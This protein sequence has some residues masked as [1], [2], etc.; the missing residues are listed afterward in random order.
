MALKCPVGHLRIHE[1]NCHLANRTTGQNAR[2]NV[3]EIS[4]TCLGARAPSSKGIPAEETEATQTQCDPALR[5]CMTMERRD[6]L[7]LPRRPFSDPHRPLI[8]WKPLKHL[9]PRNENIV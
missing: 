5:C 4:G 6:L 9:R 1:K 3:H 8:F 2:Q 7:Y